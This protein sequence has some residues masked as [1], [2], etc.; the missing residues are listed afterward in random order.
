MFRMIPLGLS[1][2]VRIAGRGF[3]D[4][5]AAVPDADEIV[6]AAFGN[7]AG[8]RAGSRDDTV[9]SDSR[10]APRAPLYVP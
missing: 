8:K 2:I 9:D 7:R 1:V 6:V 3:T 10:R 5:P 4:C